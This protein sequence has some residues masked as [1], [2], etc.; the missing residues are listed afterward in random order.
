MIPLVEP[1]EF[2]PALAEAK[3]RVECATP[4]AT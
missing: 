2:E 4:A 3:R 1:P